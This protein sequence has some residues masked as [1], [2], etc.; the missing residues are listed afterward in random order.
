MGDASACGLVEKNDCKLIV[1]NV[2]WILL[3]NEINNFDTKKLFYLYE[4]V[5]ADI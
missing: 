4:K 5:I 2:L 3:K 1:V